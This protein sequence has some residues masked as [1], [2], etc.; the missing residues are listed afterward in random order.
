MLTSYP[1]CLT[2]SISVQVVKLLDSLTAENDTGTWPHRQFT[3]K[4]WEKQLNRWKHSR[5][6]LARL[7]LTSK[8]LS[9]SILKSKPACV[10]F[11]ITF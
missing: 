11:S 8:C 6:L 4:E 1:L 7:G 3:M 2:V 5:L 10:K 9:L